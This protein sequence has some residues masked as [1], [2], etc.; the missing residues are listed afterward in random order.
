MQRRLR[1][2]EKVLIKFGKRSLQSTVVETRL[3]SGERVE[4]MSEDGFTL[5]WTFSNE[6]L[7]TCIFTPQ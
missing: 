5:N 1:E 2:N 6:M 4:T 3:K 7:H